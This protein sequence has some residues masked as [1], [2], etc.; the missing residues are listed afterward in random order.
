MK[1]NIAFLYSNDHAMSCVI[2]KDV[3]DQMNISTYVVE[4]RTVAML[5]DEGPLKDFIIEEFGEDSY[6]EEGNFNTAVFKGMDSNNS[7]GLDKL[8][9]KMNSLII[10][11]LEA[12]NENTLV[13]SNQLVEAGLL[14][15]SNNLITCEF[16]N[17]KLY[18]EYISID[19]IR[20][21]SSHYIKPDDTDVM[22]YSLRGCLIDCWNYLS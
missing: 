1:N 7:P 20:D 22:I 5:K 8:Q 17:V 18:D 21:I 16:K 9:E 2:A 13:I 6:D 12:L 4:F 10:E 11:E 14:H 15:L 3:S 19:S